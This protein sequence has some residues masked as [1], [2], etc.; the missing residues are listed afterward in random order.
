MALNNSYDPSSVEHKSA[1]YGEEE[2]I[3]S[4]DGG[5][6][7]TRIGYAQQ[8]QEKFGLISMVGL[9]CTIMITWEGELFVYQYGKYDG[10]PL[11]SIIGFIFC[12]IGYTLVALCLGEL[13]SFFPTAGE[14]YCILFAIQHHGGDC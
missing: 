3:D 4:G 14:Q 10:G 5:E 1:S 11:G 2:A 13:N 8:L 6:I 7:A 9:S 12:W